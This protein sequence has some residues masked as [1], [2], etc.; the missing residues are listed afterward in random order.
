MGR[1][2]K[3]TPTQSVSEP[4]LVYYP[5]LVP[6]LTNPTSPQLPNP[7]PQQGGSMLM[8]SVPGPYCSTSH[9]ILWPSAERDLNKLL[10]IT[11]F[12]WFL[13]RFLQFWKPGTW[14][15]VTFWNSYM[16]A[17]AAF[18]NISRNK[19]VFSKRQFSKMYFSISHDLQSKKMWKAIS[20]LTESIDSVF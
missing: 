12:Y 15:L 5:A 16:T 19:K 2:D 6:Q 20:C 18:S 8:P 1:R 14:L 7:I 4:E 17:I 3:K 13:I 11:I 10:G 9:S